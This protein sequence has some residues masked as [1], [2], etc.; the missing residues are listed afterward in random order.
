MQKD[1]YL[2]SAK[3]LPQSSREDTLPITACRE[4]GTLVKIR[5]GRTE[6]E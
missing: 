2:S 3:S 6:A 1:T 5:L 4:G